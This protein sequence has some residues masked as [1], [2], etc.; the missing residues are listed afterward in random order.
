MDNFTFVDI[1]SQRLTRDKDPNICPICHHKINPEEQAWTL[2]NWYCSDPILERVFQCPNKECGHL[3]IARYLIAEIENEGNTSNLHP[4]STKMFVLKD[5]FPKSP[6]PEQFP[7]EIKNISPMF[8]LIY[9]QAIEAESHELIQISGMGY[10]KALEFLIKDYCIKMYPEH[11]NKIKVMFLSNCIADFVDDERIKQCA[12]RAVWLGN[13]ETHYL[14]KWQD[15]DIN[16]LKILTKLTVNWIEN[17]LL[18]NKYSEG[19]Q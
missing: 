5:L 12:K 16:D 6:K 7:E 8:I 10:R 13:D 11:D 18:T 17:I 15:K 4:T 3:F 2:T 1:Q 9:N 19:M 14:R